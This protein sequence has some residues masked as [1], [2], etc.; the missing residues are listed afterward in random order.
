MGNSVFQE[1]MNLMRP[2]VYTKQPPGVIVHPSQRRSRA[3]YIILAVFL[4]YTGAHNFY[5]GYNTRA[6]YQ[7]ILGVLS[8]VLSS[9]GIGVL[10]FLY[11]FISAIIDMFN[12]QYDAYGI[13]FS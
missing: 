5:A 8:I 12:T 4:S 13:Q 3:L 1:V 9:M 10:L 11:V 7:L 2:V 6:K